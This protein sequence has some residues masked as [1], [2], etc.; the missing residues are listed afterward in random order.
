MTESESPQQSQRHEPDALDPRT[1]AAWC[2]ALAALVAVS[3]LVMSGLMH[4]FQR[5]AGVREE[6]AATRKKTSTP[7]D[8]L[9]QAR[10]EQR[11]RLT[12]YG[13]VDPQ[14]KTAVRIPIERAMQLLLER[15]LPVRETTPDAE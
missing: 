5:Q 11:R 14:Q 10:A 4:L 2:G 3:L 6:A 9:A 15:E 12:E 7:A 13:W 8:E 1:M